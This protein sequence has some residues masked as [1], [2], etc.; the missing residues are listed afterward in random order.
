MIAI[1]SNK[2]S[3]DLLLFISLENRNVDAYDGPSLID[4]ERK[5]IAI[6]NAFP[7]HKLF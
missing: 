7:L 2:G 3:T 1:T 4:S 5:P 6:L